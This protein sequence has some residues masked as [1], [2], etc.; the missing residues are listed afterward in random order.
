VNKEIDKQGML[1]FL[2]QPSAISFQLCPWQIADIQ[3]A[4]GSIR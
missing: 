4:A 2:L 3:F 1:S